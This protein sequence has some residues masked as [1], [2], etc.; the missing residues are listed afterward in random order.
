VEAD[1]TNNG[2]LDLA[3]A[4]FASN[5]VSLLLG[6]GDGTFTPGTSILISGAGPDALVTASFTNDGN[7]DLAVVSKATNQVSILLGNGNGT[8]TLK[9]QLT[10]G[11]QPTAV[12][13]GSFSTSGFLDLAVT[14]FADNTIDV[15]F[16]NGDG[17]FSSEVTLPT[18]AGPA[19]IFAGDVTGDG[20]PDLVTAN[21]TAST[22]SVLLGDGNAGFSSNIDIAVASGP[23]A[24]A[25]G[26]FNSG[27]GGTLT[28][29]AVA[30]EAA[31]A[32]SVLINTNAA[33]SVT[34]AST[35]Q[36]PYP[37]TGYED[38]GIK[39]K[40]TPRVHPNHEVTLDLSFDITTLSGTTINGIPVIGNRSIQQTVRLKENETSILS[41]MLERQEQRSLSGLPGLAQTGALADVTSGAN[42]TSEDTELIIAITPRLLH[43]PPSRSRAVYAGRGNAIERN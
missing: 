29:L 16:G 32:V 15:F 12:T 14:N 7:A 2:K 34:G 26:I 40:A 1:F 42:V 6:N 25:A 28:D 37:A 8:F 4:N 35:P 20:I 23:V 39:V 11:N 24:I 38:I 19:A 3:T 9:T 21:E 31:N 27:S 30:G 33:S 17:T 43:L 5:S 18:G 13:T 41:G 22:I 36:T 10:T